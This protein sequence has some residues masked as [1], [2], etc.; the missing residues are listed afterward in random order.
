MTAFQTAACCLLSLLTLSAA[1]DEPEWTPL[2]TGDGEPKGFHVTAWDDVS[3]PPP[4]GARWVVA[5]GVLTGSTPRGTWLVSDEEYA[6]FALELE[7]KIGPSGN[8][9][10]GLRFPAA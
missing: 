5:D 7:F 2:F 10:I 1:P 3:K 4:A 6:D 9:G 8:S